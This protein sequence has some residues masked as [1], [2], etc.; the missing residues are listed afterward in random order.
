MNRRQRRAMQAKGGKPEAPI[1]L[2]DLSGLPTCPAC[3]STNVIGNFEAPERVE[4]YSTSW[5][6]YCQACKA[7]WEAPAEYGAVDDD[8]S[9]F[10]FKDPCDN[11][12]FRPG[13]Q[14]MEDREAWNAMVARLREDGGIFFCH[15][16]VPI[17]PE[18]ED[19]FAYP[20]TPDGRHDTDRM[21][22]CRGF[23]NAWGKWMKKDFAPK[24]TFADN[25]SA[26]EGSG[27]E[28]R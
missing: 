25:L 5:F 23:L 27:D 2:I 15:K 21:R 16:H 7:I 9:L 13:S 20:K 8:G 17:A 11:C 6:G 3:S 19:G 10:A 26:S 24:K 12:A 18:S 22:I 4:F 1:T 14:E 28:Q